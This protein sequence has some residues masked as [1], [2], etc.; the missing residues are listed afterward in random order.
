MTGNLSLL[1]NMSPLKS[2]SFVTIANGTKT[3]VQGIGTVSTPTLT[4]S[5]VLYL[6][7]F[8]FNLLSVRKLT[9]SLNC[10]VIFYPTRCVFQDLKTKRV[11]GGGFEKDGLYYFQPLS[12][13]AFHSTFSPY[14]WHCRLG[15]PSSQSLHHLVPSLPSV[16]KFNCDTCELSKHQ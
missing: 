12:H 16:V 9:Q 6:P 3:P 11:I 1:S 13:T 2:P 4:F 10:S 8:P 7:H 5:S 14:Q 15:H